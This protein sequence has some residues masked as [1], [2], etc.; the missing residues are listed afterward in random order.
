MISLLISILI[1][2]LL[3]KLLWPKSAACF[4]PAPQI[5]IH[6]HSAQVL[7]Q[8]AV[9]RDGEGDLSPRQPAHNLSN[10]QRSLP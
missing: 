9:H 3:I 1:G 2:W 7:L 5:V 4:A 6:I 8:T 10:K